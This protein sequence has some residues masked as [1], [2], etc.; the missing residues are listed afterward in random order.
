MTHSLDTP[1]SG[2]SG[3]TDSGSASTT[4][5]AKDE[6]R[7]V[8]Q[9]T[10]Q[11]GKQVAGTAAEQ[12]QQVT[13]ET[14]RQA[15]D[16]L[17]QGRQQATEQARAGQ[18]KAA[19]SLSA[20]AEELRAMTDGE[21]GSGPAHDLVRQATGAVDTFAGHLRDREPGDLLEDV[22]RFAR[23]RP[24]AFLLGAAVA[25]VLAGRLTTGVV[26][27]HKD[28]G[29]QGGQ[30][31]SGTPHDVTTGTGALPGAAS[32]YAAVPPVDVPPT[33]AGAPTD[34]GLTTGA[35]YASGPGYDPTTGYTPVPPAP[36]GTETPVV[37]PADP[38]RGRA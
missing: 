29:G 28:Q 17:S 1:T 3:G 8:G 16:L 37:P 12:A 13:Q 32:G 18:Q 15:A 6:A 19:G 5:V 14:R 27:A 2:T 36:Y 26:A 23:R 22:R 24:G 11:A 30:G 34:A 31:T 9:T 38:T 7:S 25:G 35:G 33:H 4:D 10:A 21:G 20:L